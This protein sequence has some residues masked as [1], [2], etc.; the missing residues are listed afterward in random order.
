VLPARVNERTREG[1]N[2]GRQQ[3]QADGGQAQ[4]ERAVAEAADTRS[5]SQNRRERGT[6]HAAIC[7]TLHMSAQKVAGRSGE[8]DISRV[9]KVEE[10]MRIREEAQ[11]GVRPHAPTQTQRG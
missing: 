4:L 2:E 1:S 3:A 10:R 7:A 11:G 9:V 5:I 8:F 6:E